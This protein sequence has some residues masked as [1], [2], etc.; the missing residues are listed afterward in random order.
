MAAVA[1]LLGLLLVVTFI[2]NFLT[3]IVPNQM[4]VNDLNH[5]VA[6]QNQFGRLSALL[7]SA[8]AE[9][10]V[11]MQVVQPISLGSDGVA[12]WASPDG[13][14]VGGGRN[15]SNLS[16]SYGILGAVVYLPSEGSSQGGPPLPIGCTFTSS[17]DTGVSCIGGG[18]G[19]T[20]NFSGNDQAFTL[21]TSG[22]SSFISVNYSTNGST[23]AISLSGSTNILVGLYGSNN[24]VTF[25]GLG[26]GSLGLIIVGNSNYVNLG[27]TGGATVSV[28][29]YGDLN[30]VYQTAGGGA[31]V[32]IVI[33]G[34]QNSFTG[35]STGGAKYVAYVTGFNATNPNSTLCPYNN[36]SSTDRLHGHGTGGTTYNATYNNTVYTGTGSQAPWKN[37][38]QNVGQ[39]LCPYF[40][41]QRVALGG[42]S[43][44]G[45]GVILRLT[46]TYAPSGE[47]A[48]DEGAV[49]YA[50]YGA[51]PII[52][53]PPSIS[54]TT[55]GNEV[56]AA[57]IWVPYFQ[58][59]LGSVAG[60][61]TETLNLRM[62]SS[63]SFD[64]TA[65]AG[66][67]AINSH[68][69]IKIVI[70]TPY[71]EAW[72]S[73]LR[74]HLAFSGLWT[75]APVLVCTGAYSQGGPIGTVTITIPTTNLASLTIGDSVFSIALS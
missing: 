66:L 14:S 2:A 36:L 4:Q 16:L 42:Q 55:V 47:V 46:N 9:G 67:Y 33:F 18:S 63:G 69:P 70:H 21:S 41:N 56:T 72:D 27:D 60:L 44:F 23:I 61:G 51:Y 8:G 31:N 65:S 12:P 22:S 45:E 48:Y 58:G 7:A 62:L 57:S 37:H 71:A 28:S 11:G 3:T 52:V 64:A 59:R 34:A 17:S 74:A 25:S 40:G 5:E 68:V 24:S 75:C 35:N 38:Y 26:S 6:V 10:S 50:Q 43:L 53:D 30:T 29:I 73:Y 54:L 13:S 49:I 1:T 15:G 20:Y 39:S 32:K 19:L